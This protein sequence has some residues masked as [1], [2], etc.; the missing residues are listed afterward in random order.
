M[1]YFFS[2]KANRGSLVDLSYG[3]GAF[4]FRGRTEC[5]TGTGVRAR[6]VGEDPNLQKITSHNVGVY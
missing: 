6:C 5:T 2:V 3:N 4:A 1:F